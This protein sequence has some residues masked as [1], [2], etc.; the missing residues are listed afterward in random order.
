MRATQKS[1]FF[2]RKWT[3]LERNWPFS[4]ENH[5]VVFTDEQDYSLDKSFGGGVQ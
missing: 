4:G 5:A 3:I 2:N 1:S